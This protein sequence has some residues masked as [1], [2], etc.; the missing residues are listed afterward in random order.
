[1]NN[2]NI[3]LLSRLCIEI[4]LLAV[5]CILAIGNH[6]NSAA[7]M[8]ILGAIA[9]VGGVSVGQAVSGQNFQRYTD[10]EHSVVT[11][12]LD[13]LAKSTPPPEKP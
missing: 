11:R 3:T 12:A 13:A 4:A 1:M 10:S 9:G 5:V 7:V 2:S 6:I 8:A